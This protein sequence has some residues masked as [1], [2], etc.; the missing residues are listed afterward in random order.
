MSWASYGDQFTRQGLWDD[1]GYESRWHYFALVEE[2]VRGHRWD[3]RLPLALARR[4]SDVPDPD[5]CHTELERVGVLAVFAERVELTY[6]EHHIPPPGDRPDV[7]LPRKRDNQREYRRRKCERGEHDR[8]CPSA[9][10]PVKGEARRRRVAGRV[11]G[12]PESSRVESSSENYSPT[13]EEGR[14]QPKLC[15]TCR[16]PLSEQL[17][18]AEWS[19]HP[20]EC[21]VPR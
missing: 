20:G 14:A 15:L 7:L 17:V 18:A 11:A 13:E 19:V 12:N 5:K 6:I 8:H 2:C 1:V 10:C 3:G 9:T 21:E 4:T 16:E